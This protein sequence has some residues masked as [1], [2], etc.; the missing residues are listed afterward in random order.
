MKKL[1]RTL[2]VLA[3]V[4]VPNIALAAP[5]TSSVSFTN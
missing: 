1:A 2:L 4:L 3:V 5:W